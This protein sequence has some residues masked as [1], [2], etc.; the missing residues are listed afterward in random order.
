[1]QRSLPR[2]QDRAEPRRSSERVEAEALGCVTLERPEDI[3]HKS[4]Q[5]HMDALHRPYRALGL[6]LDEPGVTKEHGS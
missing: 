3:G 1:V 4:K 6:A 2:L 5:N